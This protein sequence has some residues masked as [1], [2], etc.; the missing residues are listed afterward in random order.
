M[1]YDVTF[2]AFKTES[3]PVT[4]G[5]ILGCSSECQAGRELAGWIPL[6][7]C[8]AI[9]LSMDLSSAWLQAVHKESMQEEQDCVDAT[10]SDLQN[11][12]P[13]SNFV[14]RHSAQNF[15]RVRRCKQP[16]TQ[17]PRA[18]LCKHSFPQ[19]SSCSSF[20]LM[21]VA[22]TGAPVA[23]KSTTSPMDNALNAI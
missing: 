7:A 5:R 12:T 20:P 13:Q 18:A 15:G 9:S 6:S 23:G 8:T 19:V 1:L 11:C 21:Q 16:V 17:D 2:H 4:H 14:P 3:A 10:Q 22:F